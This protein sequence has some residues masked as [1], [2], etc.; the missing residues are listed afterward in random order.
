[1]RSTTNI[2]A[3]IT[4]EKTRKGSHLK[5]RLDNLLTIDGQ[6]LLHAYQGAALLAH[7]LRFRRGHFRPFSGII[8]ASILVVD[9]MFFR[10]FCS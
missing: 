10:Q 7:C 3:T 1:M 6:H 4:P 9:P 2:N 8:V 5:H